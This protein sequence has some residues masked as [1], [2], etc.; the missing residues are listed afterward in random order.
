[1]EQTQSRVTQRGGY[2]RE[3][4]PTVFGGKSQIAE[5]IEDRFRLDSMIGW[6]L[7]YAD[8]YTDAL[9]EAE[10]IGPNELRIFIDTTRAP[11]FFR[12]KKHIGT[13]Y[14]PHGRTQI[15]RNNDRADSK[16]LPSHLSREQWERIVF[17]FRG[18][19]V[20]CG[21]APRVMTIDHL[22]P[23]CAGGGTEL[24][25]VVPAC[26]DCNIKKG[27]KMPEEFISSDRLAEILGV[28]GGVAKCY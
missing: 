25:N 18:S 24:M 22:V 4:R 1:M 2:N 11:R 13:R 23:I 14:I 8:G 5:A 16:G 28:L 17:A 26:F 9:A 6:C 7:S 21:C 27:R 12:R 15:A 3:E 20:Y 10:E 19:C